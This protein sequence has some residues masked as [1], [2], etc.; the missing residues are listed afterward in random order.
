MI[1]KTEFEQILV[2]DFGFTT[3]ANSSYNNPTYKNTSY[4]HAILEV[5]TH[6]G[7]KIECKVN[8]LLVIFDERVRIE[9]KSANGMEIKSVPYECIS[10][11]ALV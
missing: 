8:T 9:D 7:K 3:I 10:Y 6:C 1:N 5:H 11:L 2:T 4:K